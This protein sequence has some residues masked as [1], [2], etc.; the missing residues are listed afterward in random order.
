MGGAQ[1]P[2]QQ[3]SLLLAAGKFAVR[4]AAQL[5]QIQFL[6]R[7]LRQAALCRG[8]K[9]GK[10]ALIH[11][12][13]LHHLPYTGGKIFLRAGLLR[14]IANLSLPQ[15][16]AKL[17]G[18]AQR[19]LKRKQR[20]DQGAFAGTVFSH[21]AQVISRVDRERKIGQNYV[22]FVCQTDVVTGD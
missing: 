19:A 1:C 10:S 21:D 12:A 6:Q 22:V 2:G 9:G 13:G 18:A 20:L 15:P 17:N 14:Q 5:P 8:I 4:T 7:F 3:D 11:A 16:I